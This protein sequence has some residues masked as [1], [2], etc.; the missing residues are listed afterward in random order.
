[1]TKHNG[2]VRGTKPFVSAGAGGDE[3]GKHVKVKRGRASI[4]QISRQPREEQHPESCIVDLCLFLPRDLSTSLA[5]RVLG[6][7]SPADG[8][9]EMQGL[10]YTTLRSTKTWKWT[11]HRTARPYCTPALRNAVPLISIP[12][13]ITANFL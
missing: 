10:L 13:P 6:F 8:R 5:D 4:G 12:A 3:S 9:E 11:T 2:L 1:M 7:S